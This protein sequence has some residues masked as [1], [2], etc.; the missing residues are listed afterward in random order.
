MSKYPLLI[1]SLGALLLSLT[2]CKGRTVEN[3]EPT[4]ETVDVKIDTLSPVERIPV[5]IKLK[6]KPAADD[7]PEPDAQEA[8]GLDPVSAAVTP[9][10]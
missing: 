1:A 2:S 10:N 7:T 8:E 5:D 9:A 3:M 4:G 6:S